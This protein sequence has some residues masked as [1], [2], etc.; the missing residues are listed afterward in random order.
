MSSR[1]SFFV[2]VSRTTCH[3]MGQRTHDRGCLPRRN[4]ATPQK[5]A[6][7]DDTVRLATAATALVVLV[8]LVAGAVRRDRKKSA[9]KVK[10]PTAVITPRL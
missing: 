1:N 4:P 7:L 6:A 2:E 8:A 3:P 5:M 10:K 9:P